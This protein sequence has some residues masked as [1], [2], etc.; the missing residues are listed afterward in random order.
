MT[1]RS[2]MICFVILSTWPALVLTQNSDYTIMELDTLPAFGVGSP[3][4]I[5]ER[6]QIAGTLGFSPLHAVMWDNGNLVD[7]QAISVPPGTPGIESG[8]LG[9]CR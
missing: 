5:N 6:G 9:C 4:A 2:R 7:L 8:P 3:S 1:H